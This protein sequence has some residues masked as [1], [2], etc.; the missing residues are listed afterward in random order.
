MKL[1]SA[2]LWCV[3]PSL[4]ANAKSHWD[5]PAER[6]KDAYKDYLGA[7][8]PIKKDQIKHFV[9]F[10]GDRRSLRNHPLLGNERFAGA[11]IMYSWRRLEPKKDKYDFS[12][13]ENDYTYLKSKNKKL[14]IQL[15]DATFN[16][17]FNAVPGYL[18]SAEYDGGALYQ[19]NDDGKPDGWVAKRWNKA[20]QQRFASLLGALGNRFDGEIEGINLQESAIGV[21]SEYDSSFTPEK[22]VEALKHNMLALKEAFPHSTT[23]QY[24]NFIPGEWLPWEDKGYLRSIYAYGEKIGVGL[25][26]LISW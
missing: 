7:E 1:R 10:A 3:L 2:L 18:L 19:R 6:Y 4:N 21:S 11:Q 5:N 12:I 24:A 17:K 13:I 23:M 16:V 26:G 8:C 14:F 20:V 25:G 22:Y 15:Q 9:Y